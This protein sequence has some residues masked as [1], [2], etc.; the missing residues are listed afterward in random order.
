MKGKILESIT[1]ED[2]HLVEK[3]HQNSF[4]KSLDLTKKRQIRKCDELISR[5]KV[6]HSAREKER[7]TQFVPKY[8]SHVKVPNLLRIRLRIDSPRMSTKL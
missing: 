4:K 1:L 5:K 2:F 3:I 7:L 8:A 6:T